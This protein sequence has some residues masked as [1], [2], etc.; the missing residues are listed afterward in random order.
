M[1]L[2]VEVGAD[3][4]F[5][6]VRHAVT[7]A[8]RPPVPAAPDRT[9]SS[10]PARCSTGPQVEA[11]RVG[12]RC[13]ADILEGDARRVHRRARPATAK[14]DLLV[15]G[16]RGHGALASALIGSVSRELLTALPVPV[17]VVRGTRPR[18]DRPPD[19]RRRRSRP[20]RSRSSSRSRFPPPERRARRSTRRARTRSCSGP[21]TSSSTC[22]PTAAPPRSRRSSAPRWSWAT[23][24]MPARAASSAWRRRCRRPTATAT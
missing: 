14:A 7:P 3:V 13:E 9:S 23:S 19:G 18:R 2:A 12:V 15:V 5:V 11:E 1:Q 8:R 4:T 21:R 16:S 22:S 20:G 17:M 24:R 6:T 10:T